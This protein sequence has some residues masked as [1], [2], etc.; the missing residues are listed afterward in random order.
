METLAII[1]FVISIITF[2]AFILDRISFFIK[3]NQNTK[4]VIATMQ[5]AKVIFDKQYN[6][7]VLV[8]EIIFQNKTTVGWLINYMYLISDNAKVNLSSPTLKFA[9]AVAPNSTDGKHIKCAIPY[10]F[11]LGRNIE[12]HLLSSGKE[13]VY[14]QEL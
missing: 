9:V 8:A 2:L 14:S 5:N 4:T 7:N 12:L 6:Q 1:S 11:T 3:R 13:F 10:N